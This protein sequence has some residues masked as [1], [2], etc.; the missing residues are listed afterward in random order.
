[1]PKDKSNFLGFAVVAGLVVVGGVA[2]YMYLKGGIGDSSSPL[3]SAKVVPSTALMAT[4]VNTD[5][6]SWAKLK[7]FGTSQAQELMTKGLQDLNQ[8]VFSESQ[9]SYEQDIQPWIGGVMIAVLPP[10]PTKPVQTNPSQESNILLVVGIKDKVNALNFANKLKGLKTV[11]IQESDYKG[12][13]IIESQGKGKPTYTVVLNNSHLLLAPERKAVEQAIDTFK[14]GDS[15]AGKVG[16]NEILG[17]GVDVKNSLAQI[18]IPDYANTVQQLA[19][20]SSQSRQLPPSTLKQMQQVKSLVAAVGV[21]DGG[22]RLKAI[23]NLD[24]ELS[25]FQ[26]Q[27]T[28]ANIVGQFPTETFALVSGQGISE[29]WK[30]ITEQS[31]EYPEIK[32]GIELARGQLKFVNIDL[33]QDIFSWMN[34]EF[35]VGA[36]ES[37]QGVL[38]NVGFGLG[39]VFDTSDRAT[40]TNTFSKLDE[41]AK[42]QSLTVA[43]RKIGDKDV[44]EWQI[45]QQGALVAHGWL[46]Q[47]TVFLALGGAIA[48]SIADR[49]GESLNNT[50]SFKVV[51]GSLQKPNGGY[52]YLDMDKTK[53]L[54]EKFATQGSPLPPEAEAVL[55]SIRGFG[56]TVNSPNKSTSQMEMFLALKSGNK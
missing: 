54:I 11:K 16:A 15:F 5:S 1:M 21:D 17:A 19:G 30:T 46:D 3:G 47:D 22:L 56:V 33:D 45:P 26:Y 14:G 49:K 40:A 23:A 9:I 27:N 12:E 50:D 42:Q 13:K 8:E 48:D 34:G 29:S 35:A 20:L 25:K 41:I 38:A 18:Y 10:N 7:Q 53:S 2:A 32:Q 4:Y 28:P 44:T 51:T 24:P 39:L 31:Q 36:I 55:S 52:F 6:Q 37:K 43:Q